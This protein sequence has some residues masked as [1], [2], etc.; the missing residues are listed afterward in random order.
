M[1]LIKEIEKKLNELDKIAKKT[2]AA[3]ENRNIDHKLEVFEKNVEE[4][5]I[6]FEKKIKHL[7]KVYEEKNCKIT[8]LEKQ[9]RELNNKFTEFNKSEKRNPKKEFKCTHCEFLANTERGL[10]THVTRIHTA[11]TMLETNVPKL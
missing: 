11:S 9:L 2:E 4:K 8:D 1:H 5:I 3:C 6:T 7:N 10:K